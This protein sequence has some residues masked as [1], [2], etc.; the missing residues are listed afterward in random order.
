[1]SKSLTLWYEIFRSSWISAPNVPHYKKSYRKYKEAQKEADRLRTLL[2]TGKQPEVKSWHL[3]YVTFKELAEQVEKN[4]LEKLADGELH[5][6]TYDGYILRLNLFCEIYGK[7][8][9][10]S[11]N[12][13]EIREPRKEYYE[14]KSAATSN[15]NLF[16][17]KQVHKRAKNIG[18]CHRDPAK[19]IRYLSEKDHEKKIPKTP[20]D[21]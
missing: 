13:E 15:R 11:I 20:W 12:E 19:G 1:M 7:R 9:I 21:P 14:K 18:A 2:D 8:I 5:Q 3:R 4:W 17:L 10:S 6:T 16:I